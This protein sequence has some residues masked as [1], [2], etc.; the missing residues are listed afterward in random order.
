[1]LPCPDHASSAY[2]PASSYA[3]SHALT[4]LAAPT[5][6]HPHPRGVQQRLHQASP[7]T[8]HPC[9]HALIMP[10]AT[11]LLPHSMLQ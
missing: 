5:A 9:C 1:M 10:T 2:G 3:C 7:A 4:M 6:L 8:L 11:T